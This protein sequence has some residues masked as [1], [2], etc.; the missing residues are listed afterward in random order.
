[1]AFLPFFS[2][3]PSLLVKNAEFKALGDN[4]MT[5]SACTN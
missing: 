2:L 4:M 3:T 5:S 1:M